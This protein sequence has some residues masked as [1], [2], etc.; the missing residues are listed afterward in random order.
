[1]LVYQECEPGRNMV[2]R[3]QDIKKGQAAFSCGHKIE[4][5]HVGLLAW[6]G[7]KQAEVFLPPRVAIL[8]I[9][10][11]GVER[12]EFTWPDCRIAVQGYGNR[13]QIAAGSGIWGR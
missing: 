8:G 9:N 4:A 5:S 12:T 10:R 1:M 13:E 11:K 2:C 7:F 6:L 3:G